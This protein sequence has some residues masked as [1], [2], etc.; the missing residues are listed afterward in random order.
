MQNNVFVKKKTT[1]NKSL[2]QRN[3]C[4]FKQDALKADTSIENDHCK[5]R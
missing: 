4:C 3:E 1:K 5:T 2:K